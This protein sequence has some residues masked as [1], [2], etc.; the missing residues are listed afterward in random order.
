M[1][2]S[3]PVGIIR[4]ETH[5]EG[6][7][8]SKSIGSGLFMSLLAVI[9]FGGCR[10][11]S[12]I[13]QRPEKVVSMRETV[14]DTETYA[15]LDSLWA[16][17]YEVYPSEDA[18]A[19]WM[20]AARYAGNPGFRSLLESGV[21][22]YPA[23]PRLLYL[24]SMLKHGK[25]QNLEALTL[26]E[27]AVELDP[28]YTDPWFSLVIHYLERGEREKTLVALRKILES[29]AVQDEVLDFSYNMLAS[30]EKNAVLVTNGDNDTYPG[31][32]LTRL[33][34]FRP[35]VRLVNQSLLNTDWYP[36]TLEAEGLPPLVT[37]RELDS[38]KGAF[39]QRLKAAGNDRR[40]P[41]GPFS[42][43]LV[44]RLVRTCGK[45]GR[46]VYFAATLQ[47]SEAVKRLLTTGRELGL[48]TLVTPPASS[49]PVQV[50]TAVNVW[51]QEFRT[52]GLDGWGVRYARQ[53]RA[54]RMLV[55]NYAFALR[56][57]MDRIVRFAPESRLGLFRWYR[58]H[59]VP[60]V[61]AYNREGL[62]RMW[63]RSDDIGEIREWCRSK[64]LSK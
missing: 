20:Y 8:M 45:A 46:P 19:N 33:M 5:M 29:G 44:E 56:S 38:L 30:L 48:A 17:Y 24:Q 14:Y 40:M 63:C 6:E 62:D 31:W 21:K 1:N 58:D 11:E 4:T 12:R 47:H 15:A 10:D 37:T 41:V 55:Q 26:L 22:R 42:D 60:L 28:T 16:R 57:Q 53:S 35:D 23:N 3:P 34:G 51:L 7:V 9:A 54:G 39:A 43:E 2:K 13:V 27:R 64:N 61:P 52:G 32:I 59:L 50:R 18:Y 25:P 36:L 49:D